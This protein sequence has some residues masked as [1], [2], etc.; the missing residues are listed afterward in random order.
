MASSSSSLARA[1]SLRS[2]DCLNWAKI[3]RVGRFCPLLRLPDD[4]G[5]GAL[6]LLA[7]ANFWKSIVDLFR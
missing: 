2:S 3:S 1:Y 7:F 6:E 4:R 5:E